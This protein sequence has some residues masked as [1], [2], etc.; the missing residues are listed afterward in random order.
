MF[1]NNTKLSQ[2]QNNGFLQK[3]LNSSNPQELLNN[4]IA[5]NPQLKNLMSMLNSSGMSPKQFFYQYAQQ[6]GINPDQFIE[7]LKGK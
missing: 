5:G 3:C 2:L 4:M 7:S 1:Q 6:N